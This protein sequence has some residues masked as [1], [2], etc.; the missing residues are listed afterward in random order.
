MKA[1]ECVF[2]FPRPLVAAVNGHAIAGGCLLA[3][4]ADYRVMSGGTIGIPELRVG[5]PFPAIAVEILR[6][7]TGVEAA[8][9]ALLG[10]VVPAERAKDLRLADE[11][12]APEELT[13]RALDQARSLASMAP[14]AFRLTKANLRLP[15]LRNA[16][17]AAE[18]DAESLRIWSQRETHDGISAYLD[19]VLHKSRKGS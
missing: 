14:E 19:R 7:A 3:A 1:L 12:V 10:D 6:F 13:A 17:A 4:A 15:C 9:H 11:V 16:A 2:S 5:V 8:R 18:L